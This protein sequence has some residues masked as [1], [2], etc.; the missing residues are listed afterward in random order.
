M[1][2]DQNPYMGPWMNAPQMFCLWFEMPG[3]DQAPFYQEGVSPMISGAQAYPA[4]Y[5]E[6]YQKLQPSIKSACD[7]LD[8]YKVPTDDMIDDQFNKIF[9]G[10]HKVFPELVEYARE[11]EIKIHSNRQ[12]ADCV[13]APRGRLN[14]ECPGYRNMLYDLVRILFLSELFIRRGRLWMWF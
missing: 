3:T 5:P 10:I 12:A 14:D 11:Y 1:I 8:K 6:I 13:S 7:A 9:D 2:I 4:L